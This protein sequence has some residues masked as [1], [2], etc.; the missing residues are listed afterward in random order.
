M[1]QTAVPLPASVQTP[2]A[3][4]FQNT[5][6]TE[7]FAEMPVGSQQ[8]YY[9]AADPNPYANPRSGPQR[10]NS[11]SSHH[12]RLSRAPTKEVRDPNLDTNLPYRTLSADANLAEY[13]AEVPNGEIT[14]PP[15]PDGS[16]YYKL[17]AFTP[18]DKE[19]PKN[20]SKAYK[21]YCTMV[22]AVTCFVVAFCSSVITADIEG[23]M[24][25]FNVSE[26]AALVSISVFVVGFGVGKSWHS[27]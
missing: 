21:W 11:S 18:G 10:T 16:G 9:S 8:P 22:V 14:G 12:S 24:E 20:W 19:N 13:T 17:V 5:P 3:T 23:V 25:T 27:D 15:K 6:E 2:P 26:E 7:S 1:E 4:H